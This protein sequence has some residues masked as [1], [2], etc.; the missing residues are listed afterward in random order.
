MAHVLAARIGALSASSGTGD[1][2]FESPITA[3]KP[4]DAVM[5]TGDTTEYLVYAAD[6]NGAATGQWEVG[7]GTYYGPEVLGGQ[8]LERTEPTDNSAGTAGALSFSAGIKH[9][10]ISPLAQRLAM[11]PPGGGHGQTLVFDA[12]EGRLRWTGAVYPVLKQVP[13]G[14]LTLYVRT[15]GNDANSGTVNSAAGAFRTLGRAVSEALKYDTDSGSVEVKLANGNYASVTAGM[16]DDMVVIPGD[17]LY[18]DEAG[19][20]AYVQIVGNDANPGSVSIG[21]IACFSPAVTFFLSGLT[22]RGSIEVNSAEIENCVFDYRGSTAVRVG[23]LLA[24]RNDSTAMYPVFGTSARECKFFRDKKD[25]VIFETLEGAKLEVQ[26]PEFLADSSVQTVAVLG[27]RS[28]FSLAGPVTGSILG[29]KF[30]TG[31]FCVVNTY[32]AGA[33]AM[34]GDVDGTLSGG[35]VLI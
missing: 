32:G 1:I 16:F 9:V 22:V 13:D 25:G 20:T 23:N 4:F 5:A 8:R 6:S 34:P 11:I 21:Q 15:D 26:N 7:T 10:V 35:S 29:K 2:V 28:E 3:H 24:A 14:E 18:G 30:S 19:K 31:L 12:Q 33:A 17:T 27:N